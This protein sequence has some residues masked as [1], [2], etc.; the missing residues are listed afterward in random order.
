MFAPQCPVD[1]VAEA[2]AIEQ[3]AVSSDGFVL[4]GLPLP[5]DLSTLHV[6]ADDVDNAVPM[7][8]TL[9]QTDFLQRRLQLLRLKCRTLV[10]LAN[11]L[12]AKGMHV[13]LH[14]LRVSVCAS[15]THLLR[16][17]S[18][19]L[20]DAWCHDLDNLVSATFCDLLRLPKL[21]GDQLSL[22]QLPLG[23]GGFGFLSMALE[24][25]VHALAQQ[26]QLRSIE[27]LTEIIPRD[28]LTMAEELTWAVVERHFPVEQ[29]LKKTKVALLSQGYAHATR[30]LRTHLYSGSIDDMAQHPSPRLNA[31]AG[32]SYEGLF[33]VPATT[34]G[35]QLS[36]VFTTRM[37]FYQ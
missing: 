5:D 36:T 32:R 3:E 10:T 9:F 29:S 28:K 23:Y 33:F 12:N 2:L 15:C 17:L 20:T 8:T 34:N 11:Q 18:T 4:C 25:P 21:T 26:L 24:G 16:A 6:A 31:T 1:Q 27:S 14:L 7:G 37:L 30:C 22:V 35:S 19:R 13:S